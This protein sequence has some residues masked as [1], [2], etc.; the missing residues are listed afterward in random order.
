MEKIKA[1]VVGYGNIG[2]YVVEAL[3]VSPDFE[4]AG[5]VRRNTKEIPEELKAY[6]V[7]NNLERAYYQEK[8]KESNERLIARK[9]RIGKL[10]GFAPMVCL[11]VGY[12]IVPL[13]VIGM[14]CYCPN[15]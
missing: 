15:L 9:G 1:A 6:K 4:I 3:Q 7:V 10:I 2:K 14:L 12:L 13:V 11:F 5:I 8:R